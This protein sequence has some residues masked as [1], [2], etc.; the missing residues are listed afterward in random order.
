MMD[1]SSFKCTRSLI[2]DEDV[3]SILGKKPNDTM[4]ILPESKDI[5]LDILNVLTPNLKKIASRERI[6]C[7]VIHGDKYEYLELKSS[8]VILPFVI[9]L[10]ASICC[11]LLILFIKKFF[12]NSQNTLKV[13]MITKK[14]NINGI[15][16]S[17]YEKIEI[18]GKAESVVEA[19]EKIKSDNSAE[20]IDTLQKK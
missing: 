13:R 6:P 16:K 2:S 7:E 14:K 15:K 12:C 11:E 17:K 8:T 9:S 3:M 18:E 1:N 19:L 10:S 20:E 4:Y 5:D